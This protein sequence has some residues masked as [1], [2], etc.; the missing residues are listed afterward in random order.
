VSETVQRHTEGFFRFKDLGACALPDIAQPAR[1]YACTGVSQVN[2]RLETFLRR[3]RSAILG[4]ERRST[5]SMSYDKARGS[6]GRLPSVVGI[7]KS[8]AYEFQGMLADV[9]ANP[10][11]SYE[12]AAPYHAFFLLCALPPPS[13]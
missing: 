3:H 5:G 6:Q 9:H 10:R 11:R 1:V 4:R 2:T 12:Q 7:G 8:L 13:T